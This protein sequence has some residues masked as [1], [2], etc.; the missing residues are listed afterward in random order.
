MIGSERRCS[1]SEIFWRYLQEV[2]RSLPQPV[3]C[4]QTKQV[5]ESFWAPGKKQEVFICVTTLRFKER[6]ISSSLEIIYWNV[7]TERREGAMGEVTAS[8][9]V[10]SSNIHQL[11]NA[12]WICWDLV[13]YLV[14]IFFFFTE[15]RSGHLS[16]GLHQWGDGTEWGWR[17][18]H[19]F[20][21]SIASG[22]VSWWQTKHAG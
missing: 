1:N 9:R 3:W 16:W 15:T 11:R 5:S 18:Q 19:H 12:L 8:T 22:A 7:W 10:M 13:R 14:L 21:P 4:H 6:T 2:L 20:Y 17:C